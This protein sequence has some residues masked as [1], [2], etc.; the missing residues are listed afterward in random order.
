LNEN[1]IDPEHSAVAA[2]GRE[3]PPAPVYPELYDVDYQLR[4]M[5]QV[6]TASTVRSEFPAPDSTRTHPVDGNLECTTYSYL[7]ATVGS[8]AG[9]RAGTQAAARATIPKIDVAKSAGWI[10]RIHAIQQTGQ[11]FR[12]GVGGRQSDRNPGPQQPARPL[13]TPVSDL[14]TL[15]AERDANSNLSHP[16]AHC[17]THHAVQSDC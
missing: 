16:P 8:R 15:R 9:R 17:V 7:R 6:T 14:S 12:Y 4:G 11:D 1:Q 3:V 2:S 5:D 13:S 10:G